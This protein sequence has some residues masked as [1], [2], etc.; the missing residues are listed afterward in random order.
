MSQL[1][2]I[3]GL[4]G[5]W[6]TAN[7]HQGSPATGEA[8]RPPSSLRRLLEVPNPKPPGPARLRLDGAGAKA[9]TRGG[10]A[11]RA[12]ESGETGRQ[13]SEPF[14]VPRKSGNSSREDPAEARGGRVTDPLSGNK[15]GHRASAPCPRNG[16]G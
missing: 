13:E 11:G 4:P 9:Q 3:R 16:S 14:I 6:N 7:A 2:G 5:S 10:I 12:Q 1:P 15:G 8:C